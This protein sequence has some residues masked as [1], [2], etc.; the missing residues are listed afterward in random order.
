MNVTRVNRSGMD[1]FASP[2]LTLQVGDRVMVVGPQDAIERVASL[3]GN[4]M[5]RLDH[6]NIVTIFVGI[7]LGILFGSLPIAFPGIPTPVKLGLA[8]GPLIV[9]IL[10]GRF[11][12]KLKLVTY[13]TMSANLMLRE[14]GIALFLASVGVKAGA[15]FLQT[16]VEGDGMLYVGCGFL[17]TII[18]LL[19]MGVFGRYYYKIN[20]FKLMGLLA[21]STTDPPA[22]AY[23]S[24]V[25]G[26]NAP[27]VGYSTVYPVTMFLRILTAQ[28]LILIL[29]S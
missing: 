15:N 16:V 14:I 28:L 20:Y 19:I 26:S 3:M 17:I 11:G 7:F 25:T 1:I 5:K 8:G 29:A 13:T 4:S 27:A 22:L 9:S 12:Y 2:D 23:A 24:Q 6:P 21:G 10:I 18:P